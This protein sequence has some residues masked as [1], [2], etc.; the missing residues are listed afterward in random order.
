[1]TTGFK[2]T[3]KGKISDENKDNCTPC[4]TN[5]CC[6]WL[7]HMST[8]NT[9]DVT[10]RTVI[11]SSNHYSLFLLPTAP[12]QPPRIISSVRS[13]SRYI[14]TWD[15]VVALSNESTV[16]GYKVNKSGL[17]SSPPHRFIP[18]NINVWS[19]SCQ[20]NIFGLLGLPTQ[21]SQKTESHKRSFDKK[22][23]LVNFR[24]ILW[25]VN[26]IHRMVAFRDGAVRTV[27]GETGERMPFVLFVW[28][29][30]LGHCH[31]PS[32]L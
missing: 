3:G 32:S 6:W 4:L 25:Q 19:F 16:T 21:K 27:C 11:Q 7:T 17:P 23:S 20:K 2:E 1:M 13:G 24:E 12:S 29:C 10:H 26:K 18:A 22:T 8:A 31:L 5:H 30:W 15:H 28:E 9:C 14:I